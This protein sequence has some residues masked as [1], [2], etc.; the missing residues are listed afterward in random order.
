MANNG[1]K[2]FFTRNAMVWIAFLIFIVGGL[3]SM[4]SLIQ[5]VPVLIGV[6]GITILSG[7]L[8]FF[9]IKFITEREYKKYYEDSYNIEHE[10][11]EDEIKK[12]MTHHRYQEAVLNRWE[13]ACRDLGILDE[14][15]DW[16]LMLLMDE[17][18][19]TD[20]ELK[21]NGIEL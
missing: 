12:S 17:R 15:R 11:I 10:T 16:L 1:I 14:Q 5:K 8:F 4:F 7:G 20:A 2:S 18:K 6:L 13:S 9:C 19:K 21:E 3:L